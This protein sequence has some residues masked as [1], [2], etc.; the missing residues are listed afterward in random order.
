MSAS[1]VYAPVRMSRRKPTRAEVSPW[2]HARQRRL[3]RGQSNVLAIGPA[4][5]T[6]VIA[7]ETLSKRYVSRTGTVSALEDISFSVGEGEFVAVVG[8]SGCGKS[9]L[10]KIL[11]GILPASAGAAHLRGTTIAGPRK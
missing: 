4:V 3:V 7:V 8:P 9:T 5:S 2:R 6:S 11:S 10:L 1:I